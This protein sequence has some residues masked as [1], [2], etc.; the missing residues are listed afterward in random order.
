MAVPSA[1]KGFNLDLIALAPVAKWR[2]T[3]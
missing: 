2:A 1:D 3:V